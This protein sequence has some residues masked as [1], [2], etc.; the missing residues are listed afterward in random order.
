MSQHSTGKKPFAMVT[1]TTGLFNYRIARTQAHT[2]DRAARCVRCFS[3]LPD[4]QLSHL[5]EP[6]KRTHAHT[7]QQSKVR[8]LS[9]FLLLV[10]DGARRL[11]CLR[12]RAI[13]ITQGDALPAGAAEDRAYSVMGFGDAF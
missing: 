10:A 11:I 12:L 3:P 6:K 4:A 2:H 8:L 13:L 7:S 5:T 9:T 1:I